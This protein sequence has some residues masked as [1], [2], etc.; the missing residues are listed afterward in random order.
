MCTQTYPEGMGSCVLPW[1]HQETETLT[2]QV[3]VCVVSCGYSNMRVFQGRVK[4][5]SPRVKK[6]KICRSLTDQINP[7]FCK[8]GSASPSLKQKN[9]ET[10]NLTPPCC[11]N[12]TT[13]ERCTQQ[14]SQENE[15]PTSHVKDFS[16]EGLDNLVTGVQILRLREAVGE[17][18]ENK[19]EAK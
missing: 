6:S 16:F 1:R 7:V 9:K 8:A 14:E 10:G 3:D 11:D 13:S 17:H 19:S 2:A 4:D 5:S 15:I 12:S 18:Q